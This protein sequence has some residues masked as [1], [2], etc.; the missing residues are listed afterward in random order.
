MQ[1]NTLRDEGKKLV[2]KIFDDPAFDLK[3]ALKS[4]DAAQAKLVKEGLIQSLLA[5]LVLPLDEFSPEGHQALGTR[6]R[7]P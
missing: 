4:Y 6:W 2:T 5:N 7:P 3:A 1:Q